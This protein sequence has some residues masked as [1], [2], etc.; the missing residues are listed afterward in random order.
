MGDASFDQGCFSW[1]GALLGKD[2][3]MKSSPFVLILEH[4]EGEEP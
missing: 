2:E 1:Q 4:M 3:G